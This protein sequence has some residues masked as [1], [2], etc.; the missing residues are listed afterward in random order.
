MVDIVN[1]NKSNPHQYIMCLVSEIKFLHDTILKNSFY[2]ITAWY[3]N[4]E[5]S[6]MIQDG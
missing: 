2:G 5:V 3:T 6:L 1:N 4:N